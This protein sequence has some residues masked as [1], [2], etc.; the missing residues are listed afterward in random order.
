MGPQRNPPTATGELVENR[1]VTNGH[2]GMPSSDYSWEHL[3]PDQRREVLGMVRSAS[4]KK[5]GKR[6]A[7]LVVLLLLLVALAVAFVII[8]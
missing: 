7:V 2:L 4:N 3:A 1:G 8:K 6:I 5:R